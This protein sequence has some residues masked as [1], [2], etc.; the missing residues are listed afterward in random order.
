MNK[1]LEILYTEHD[2]IQKA[3][4]QAQKAGEL[5]GKNDDQYKEQMQKLIFFFRTYAD[6]YHHSKEEAIL[7]PAMLEK[8]E[9][10]KDGI[11][12]EMLENHE[13]FRDLLSSIEKELNQGNLQNSQRLIMKYTEAL[14]DHIAVENDEVFIVAESLFNDNELENIFFR[15]KDSDRAIGE[16]Q[17]LELEQFQ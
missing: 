14:L 11:L 2:I 10:L 3:A 13:D 5:I 8:N 6:E 4:E 16:K 12:Q 9:L 17:K 1:F 15:F 7:F